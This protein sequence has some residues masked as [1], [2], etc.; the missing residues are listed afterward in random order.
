MLYSNG[1]EVGWEP[2]V[3]WGL[4]ETNGEEDESL[5]ANG[6]GVDWDS[7]PIVV[8]VDWDSIPNVEGVEWEYNVAIDLNESSGAKDGALY[9][10]GA[11]VD[12][13]E[14]NWNGAGVG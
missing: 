5:N 12:R 6:A 7:I 10:N 14:L 3:P 13:N 8:G 1:A 4:I 9:I 11:G 2:T